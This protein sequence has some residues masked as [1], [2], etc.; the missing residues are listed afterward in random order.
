[1]KKRSGYPG[2]FFIIQHGHKSADT[3]INLE[4]EP[5]QQD[6]NRGQRYFPNAML[7]DIDLTAHVQDAVNRLRIAFACE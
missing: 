1:M 6:C 3:R 7:K 4:D 5:V 2:C